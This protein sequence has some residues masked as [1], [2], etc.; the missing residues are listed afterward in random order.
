MPATDTGAL[1]VILKPATSDAV[2][3][4]A[5][6]TVTFA[7]RTFDIAL[8]DFPI[9]NQVLDDKVALSGGGCVCALWEGLIAVAA[10][11]ETFCLT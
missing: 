9:G 6:G 5:A 8:T 3:M 10:A 1:L 7:V 4:Q 11:P 2:E